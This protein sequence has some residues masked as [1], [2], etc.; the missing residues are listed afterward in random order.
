MIGAVGRFFYLLSVVVVGSVMGITLYNVA[1]NDPR[2]LSYVGELPFLKPLADVLLPEPN[3]T[4]DAETLG[5]GKVG[6]NQ[7]SGSSLFVR[8]YEENQ[9]SFEP[10]ETYDVT[11]GWTRAAKSVG[12]LQIQWNDNNGPVTRCTASVISDPNYAPTTLLT[13]QHCFRPNSDA[14]LNSVHKVEFVLGY[15]DENDA[16]ENLYV[17][18]AEWRNG[19]YTEGVDD[20]LDYALLH[21]DFG[22]LDEIQEDLRP[23]RL[24]LSPIRKLEPNHRLYMVHHPLDYPLV[25]TAYDC[26]AS[27]YADPD[28]VRT[29]EHVCDTLPGS[30][31]APILSMTGDYVVGLHYL[32]DKRIFTRTPSNWG[33]YI[34]SI[35]EDNEHIAGLMRPVPF[36]LSELRR[37]SRHREWAG[38]AYRKGDYALAMQIVLS[39]FPSEAKE[40]DELPTDPESI[41][42]QS[43]LIQSLI[44][45]TERYRFRLEDG[46]RS[47]ISANGAHVASARWYA[48]E[49]G[50][51]I[52]RI[53]ELATGALMH[54]LTGHE[55]NIRDLDFSADGQLMFTASDTTTRVWDVETG[56]LI[57]TLKGPNS[58]VSR[59]EFSTDGNR[60]LTEYG[61]QTV[62]VWDLGDGSLILELGEIVTGNGLDIEGVLSPNSTRIVTYIDYAEEESATEETDFFPKVWDVDS[63]EL[64]H[65]LQGPQNV[66]VESLFSPDGTSVVAYYDKQL[67]IWNAKTGTR[68]QTIE[69]DEQIIDVAFSPDATRLM[70]VHPSALRVR[71]GYTGVLFHT[72][73]RRDDESDFDSAEFSHDGARIVVI[74]SDYGV[75][76]SERKRIEIWDSE[77]QSLLHEFHR[78]DGLVYAASFLPGDSRI[79]TMGRD[80]VRMWEPDQGPLLRKF[81]GAVLHAELSQDGSRLL[82]VPAINE[83]SQDPPRIWDSNTGDLLSS[84][85][86]ETALV[87]HAKFSPNGKRVVT[88]SEDAPAK[89]WNAEN[90]ELLEVLERQGGDVRNAEFSPDGSFI[91]TNSRVRG[92]DSLHEAVSV[93]D[94]ESGA[95]LHSID[96][97][98]FVY[99]TIFAPQGDRF[100]VSYGLYG[101]DNLDRIEYRAEI[102]DVPTGNIITGLK[103]Q[104]LRFVW[105][106]QFSPDGTRIVTAEMVSARIWDSASGKLIREL[107]KDGHNMGL[108]RFSPDGLYI[109]TVRGPNVFGGFTDTDSKPLLWDAET[110]ALVRILLGHPSRVSDAAFSPYG[111]WIAAGSSEHLATVWDLQTGV[112]MQTVKGN[113][114]PQSRTHLQF[115]ADGNRILTAAGDVRIWDVW[116]HRGGENLILA[117]ERLREGNLLDTEGKPI[118]LQADCVRYQGLCEG[119]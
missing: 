5:A 58:D 51:R 9:Q 31:G 42:S 102:R 101:G 90:G 65:T 1:I 111:R 73:K 105:D 107:K 55:D 82:T 38:D 98:A 34:G 19:A 60:I 118:F 115:S 23:E 39:G 54:E 3:V 87:R 14:Q 64:V 70:T 47:V 92:E 2:T 10:L 83:Q 108:A 63:G 32:G 76:R 43:L 16:R 99:E 46:P 89:I 110:G 35:A 30:S 44:Y 88:V 93:W 29:F 112:L 22:D 106:A 41:Q 17:F 57:H 78:H 4:Y 49:S 33:Q 24:Y 104:L 52:V 117:E 12:S 48:T 86:G 74:A 119:R 113:A 114:H 36:L 15:R 77:T 62:C 69:Y 25:L 68:V 37:L 84:L 91:L 67:W 21:V 13:A 100:F 85:Q 79:I 28:R 27:E 94:A 95:L 96:D 66:I 71:D 53:F 59:A 97:L 11:F 18:P 72:I 45:N 50:D 26:R 7:S 20:K 103:G 56:S 6:Q 8:K 81:E 116:S 75:P 61:N 40:R 109:M 80:T